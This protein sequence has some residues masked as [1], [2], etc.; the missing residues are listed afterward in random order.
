MTNAKKIV[1]DNTPISAIGEQA[2][3]LSG[4]DVDIQEVD[5]TSHLVQ[6][7]VFSQYRDA[8]NEKVQLA[9]GIS[10]P[11][12]GEKSENNAVKILATQPEKW[13]I[14]SDEKPNWLSEVVDNEKSF[15]NEQSSTYSV[16]EITGQ[17][18]LDL[19]QQLSFID[20][21]TAN[22]VVLTQFANDYNG[23]VERLENA[24]GYQ[25]YITRSMAKSFWDIVKVMVSN[26]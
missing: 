17:G 22:P 14:I 2:M 19:L 10:L 12:F 5:L 1:I 13:L 15:I 4:V 25:I 24:D 23:I 21:Q 9:C 7:A 20:W 16:I 3:H 18:A 8:V 11:N 26:N 6:L